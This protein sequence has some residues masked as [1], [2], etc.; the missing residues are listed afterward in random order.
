MNLAA[1]IKS[2]DILP[3]VL[4]VAVFKSAVFTADK[5]F[6]KAVAFKT[7]CS[8]LVATKASLSPI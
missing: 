8:L 2:L 3:H 5:A 7:A 1:L 4:F 6:T